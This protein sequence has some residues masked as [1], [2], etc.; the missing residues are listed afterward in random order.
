MHQGEPNGEHKLSKQEGLWLWTLRKKEEYQQVSYKLTQTFACAEQH[1][2][3]RVGEVHTLIETMG[4]FIRSTSFQL[5]EPFNE[6]EYI[7]V[8]GVIQCWISLITRKAI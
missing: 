7:T 1:V 4:S 6:P 3:R 2:M 8:P 5:R